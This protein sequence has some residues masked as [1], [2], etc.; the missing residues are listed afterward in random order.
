MLAHPD[1]RALTILGPGGIGKTRLALQVAKTLAGRFLDGV[2]FVPLAA[3][4]SAHQLVTG[5]ADALGFAFQR[6]GD[7]QAQLLDYLR[8]KEMLL[9]LDNF[10][11]LQE[12]AGL[13][14]EVLQHA[15]EVKAIITSRVRLNLSWEWTFELGG[16]AVPVAA[17]PLPLDDLEAYSAVQLFLSSARRVRRDFSLEPAV[18]PALAR[19]CRLVEGMPLALELAAAWA[20]VATVEE[21]AAEIERGLDLLA[22]SAPDVPAR[23]RSM[24]AVLDHSW[25]FSEMY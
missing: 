1:C 15:P 21:I 2:Y 22:T 14:A 5:L 11:H 17:A 25:R 24:R 9:V 18:A 12:G 20:R 4:E 19:I 13:V 16:L 3:L 8:G 7:P 23:H 10:E 6:A